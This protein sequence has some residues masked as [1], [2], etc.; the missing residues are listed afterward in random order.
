MKR[1]A[2]SG[3]LV[4]WDSSGIS[5]FR[6]L[7]S[8]PWMTAQPTVRATTNGY[9][10]TRMGASQ[11]YPQLISATLVL[12]GKYEAIEQRLR[13][14]AA[15][16]V[17][18]LRFVQVSYKI[19]PSPAVPDK[20]FE[21]ESANGRRGWS[22]IGPHGLVA[23]DGARLAELEISTLYALRYLNADTGIPIEVTRTPQGRLRVEG[24]RCR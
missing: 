21:P 23:E 24:C 18:E 9:E 19:T 7:L 16:R 11:K 2:A 17:D 22:L 4:W 13:V 1:S 6:Q 12:N 3:L 20:T 14:R 5:R 8:R 10:V 15:N